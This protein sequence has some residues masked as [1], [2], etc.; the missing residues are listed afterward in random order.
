MKKKSIRQQDSLAQPWTPFYRCE[1]DVRDPNA[2]IYRNS[3][4]QV[5][6]RLIRAEGD[7]PEM[8]HISLRRLDRGI[9]IPF[10]DVMRMKRELLHP[11]IELVELFP[12]EERLVDTANQFHYWGIN[13]TDFR[14]PL[15]FTQ[16][17]VGDGNGQ[18]G[19]KQAFYEKDEQPADWL[20]HEQLLEVIS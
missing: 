18:E 19:G 11:E 17:L 7:H 4:Y 1:P 14:F 3:R 2:Q 13:S 12:A 8:I 20:S 10:R 6:I 9:L 5:H 15:G 16:R